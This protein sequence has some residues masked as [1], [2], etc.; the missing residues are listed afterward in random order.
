MPLSFMPPNGA[1]SPAGFWRDDALVDADDAVFEGFGDAPDAADVAAVEIG[2]ETEFG[3]IGHLDRV[4]FALEAV[5]R[6]DGSEGLL[7]GDDHVGRHIGQY[8]RLEEGAAECRALAAGDDL[9]ALLN[10]VGDVRLDLLDR[11]HVNQRPDHGTRLKPVGDLHG[12]CGLGQPLG[13]GVVD[14]VLHQNSVGAHTG[15]AGIAIFGGYRP[16]TAISMSAS[17]NTMNE[18]LPTNS[19]DRVIEE[20]GT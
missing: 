10:G 11:L 8:R 14:A 6:G 15:L 18:A 13:E 4:G 16:L 17:S 7:F 1:I 2:D 5:E 3:V 12:T 9:G 20:I 19:S